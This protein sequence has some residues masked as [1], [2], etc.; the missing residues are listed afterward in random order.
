M[1]LFVKS[2][3]LNWKSSTVLGRVYIAGGFNGQECLNSAEYYDPATN[4][5]TM[6]APMR[7][8]RSGVGVI[9]HYGHVYSVG[10]FNGITRMNNGERYNPDTNSWTNIAEMYSPRSNFG[11]EVR[12][13]NG[14]ASAVIRMHFRFKILR[15][16][17][18]DVSQLEL[19]N[20]H[21]RKNRYFYGTLRCKRT[22]LKDL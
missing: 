9:A 14:S 21:W 10:G 17:Q 15:T 18:I 20:V 7:N 6:I 12:R 19:Y 16:K 2:V 8:R 3:Q 11:I 13:H 5:W 4:Q 1:F 22:L